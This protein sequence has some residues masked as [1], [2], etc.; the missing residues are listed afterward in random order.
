MSIWTDSD[1]TAHRRPAIMDDAPATR[2]GQP[3]SIFSRSPG[4]AAPRILLVATLPWPIAARLAM[5]FAQMGCR[6]EAVCPREHSCLRTHAIRQAYPYEKLRSLATLRAAIEAATPDLII[7]CD[8]D[9]A[10][11][12]QWMHARAAAAGAQQSA[13]AACIERS[14]GSPLASALVMERESLAGLART[15]GVRMPRSAVLAGRADLDD[16]LARNPLPA[17]IKVDGSW[18][19]RGVSIVQGLE[20]AHQVFRLR[21]SHPSLRICL[22]RA[23]LERDTAPLLASIK[24]APRAVSVQEFIAGTPANRAVAC[25]QGKVLAGISVEAVRTQHSTGP[26]TVV[27]PIE[28]AE[29]AEACERL[30]RRLGVSGLWGFDFVLEAGSGSAHLIEVNPRAT[31]VCHLPLGPGRNLPAALYRQLAGAEPR[32]RPAAL[33]CRQIAL[34]PGEWRR[35]PAS[36]DLVTSHHDVPWSEPALVRECVA[37]PWSERGWLARLWAL[38]RPTG[39]R[40]PAAPRSR[41]APDSPRTQVRFPNG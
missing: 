6:V 4:T 40:P 13:L 9:A 23:L 29:M 7:P 41:P 33:D 3:M 2:F 19:G 39:P 12:L 17:V 31:P 5:A 32:E 21:A 8:D 16:W 18:G 22:A 11:C 14:L 20:E 28:C 36:S 35:D 30:V 1:W 37:L 34:F 25:W 10:R 15:E 38:L 27:R 24:N 26:A